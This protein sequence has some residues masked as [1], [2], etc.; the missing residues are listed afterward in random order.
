[1]FYISAVKEL[2]AINRIQNKYFVYVIYVC[3]YC[4]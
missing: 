3:V 4:E 1:M 2:I